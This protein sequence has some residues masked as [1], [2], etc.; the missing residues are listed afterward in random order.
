MRGYC[1][2][3]GALVSAL[4][5]AILTLS[6]CQTR[7]PGE[8][9]DASASPPR[10]PFTPQQT[11]SPLYAQEG[12]YPNLF[13]GTSYAQWIRPG[14]EM[15]TTDGDNALDSTAA[16]MSRDYVV[17]KCYLESKFAD[18]SIAYDVI[19]LRG[20]YVY[21]L[22]PDGTR[23][24]PAQRILGQKLME[25]S[26]AALRVF[27][28]ANLLVF[29]RKPGALQVPAVNGAAS[30]VRI[31]LEGYESKF[32]FA[33]SPVLPPVEQ[34]VSLMKRPGV[35]RARAGLHRMHERFLETSHKFD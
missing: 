27:G 19:G 26:R 29:P 35:R 22:L 12:L 15:A 23:V 16:S 28:R 10:V 11:R 21:L 20:L 18:M 24:P 1:I 32:Y 13:M 33:W 9:T 25:E 5:V 2:R 7:G 4:A 6:A 31:V 3:A 34:K 17:V 14:D 8:E 30:E